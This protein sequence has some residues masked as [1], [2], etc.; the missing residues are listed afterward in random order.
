MWA[1]TW[2]TRTQI[3]KA[4]GDIVQYTLE[5]TSG[6]VWQASLSLQHAQL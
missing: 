1:A 6:H 2:A 3:M 4:N 5:N